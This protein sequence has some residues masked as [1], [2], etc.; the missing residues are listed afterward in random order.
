[1]GSAIPFSEE[2]YFYVPVFMERQKYEDDYC[3]NRD[4][5]AQKEPLYQFLKQLRR[6]LG[7]DQNLF[8]TTEAFGNHGISY[9]LCLTMIH[10]PNMI[11]TQISE[12]FLKNVNSL[13]DTSP[14]S[15]IYDT[16][17]WGLIKSRVDAFSADRTQIKE[18]SENLIFADSWSGVVVAGDL[19]H[20]QKC[21]NWLMEF[22]IYLQSHWL[23]FDAY[24]ENVMRQSLSV[25]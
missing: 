17:Q 9:T 1:M 11:S 8:S 10:A 20:N 23:L 24:C 19:E 16:N 2:K 18:L 7:E 14:F 22:E 12:S 21:I 5:S 4:A 15:S 25:I 13:L 3:L 6:C